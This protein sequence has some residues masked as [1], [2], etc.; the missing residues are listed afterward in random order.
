MLGQAP[1]SEHVSRSLAFAEV[2][3][4]GPTGLAVDLGS[5]AGIPGLVLA[6]AWPYSTWALVDSNQ[7]RTRWLQST[8][9]ELGFS[10]RVSVLCERAEVLGRGHL[11]HRACLVTARGFGPPGATA[12]CAAPF[13]Q[14]G[15]HLLVADPPANAPKR[16][17]RWPQEGL[18]LL[19]LQL[20]G[21]SSVTT[22]AGP[23]SIT[24]IVAKTPC[25]QQYPRRNGL[26]AKRPLF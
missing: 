18:E 16:P 23:T 7:R 4:R 24:S 10:R 20:E 5:G 21:T 1:I 2:A 26:P 11:R 25:P 3:A 12:E 13:L 9:E 19:G 14:P 8:V 15:G 6:C 17:E 22:P